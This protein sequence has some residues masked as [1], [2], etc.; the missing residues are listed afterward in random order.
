MKRSAA[1]HGKA[2]VPVRPA[3]PTKQKPAARKQPAGRNGAGPFDGASCAGT[4]VLEKQSSKLEGNSTFGPQTG[5]P[6]YNDHRSLC[7]RGT[8]SGASSAAR[9][10]EITKNNQTYCRDGHKT[11]ACFKRTGRL[12]ECLRD[13][14]NLS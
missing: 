12:E 11:A 6:A 10:M 3:A 13:G 5:F 8:A 14:T 7:R 2:A 1:T 4:R 9:R